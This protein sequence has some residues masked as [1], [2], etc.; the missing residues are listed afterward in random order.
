MPSG[1]VIKTYAQLYTYALVEKQTRAGDYNI[2]KTLVF[3]D[4][5]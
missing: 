5:Q 2:L 3:S 4:F 1:T